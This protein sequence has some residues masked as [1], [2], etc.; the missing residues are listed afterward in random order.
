MEATPFTTVSQLSP[1]LVELIY[2][3][4][5]LRKGEPIMHTPKV[6]FC[7]GFMGSVSYSG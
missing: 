5:W 6:H 2:T 1:L 4:P 3:F 7:L